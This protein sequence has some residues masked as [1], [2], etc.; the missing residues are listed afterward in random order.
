M[1]ALVA[2][3]LLVSQR[4]PAFAAPGAACRT[5]RAEAG[6][7]LRGAALP[8]CGAGT[9]ARSSSHGVICAAAAAS[10]ALVAARRA[11]GPLR[12]RAARR[13]TETTSVD[14]LL[15]ANQ[16]Q[17]E[18][19]KSA[20]AKNLTGQDDIWVLRYALQHPGD[21]AAAVA[22]VREVLAWRAGAGKAIV[23]AAGA[24]VAAA[25]A[26]GGWD[27]APVIKAAPNADK[28]GKFLT[29]KSILVLSTKDGDLVSCIRAAAIDSPQMMKAVTEEEL[30]DFFIYAREVNSLVA[31][32]RTRKTGRLTRLVAANDLTGVSS[33]PDAKFQTALTESSKKAVTLYPGLAGPTVLLNLPWLARALVGLLAPLFP[34]A[35]RDKLKFARTPMDYMKELTDIL[36][37]PVKGQFL[38]DLQA[39]LVS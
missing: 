3:A 24:A 34:G 32:A 16:A 30:I 38:D 36:K 19:I 37:D 22:N 35:V 7:A 23:D 11:P 14:A 1:A 9:Q 33:F 15:K 17:I 5:E 2:A 13:A 27:N 8:G 4:R 28:V 31:E 6:L 25:T 12:S 18:E 10:L 29:P 21:T 39:V 20:C 26:G